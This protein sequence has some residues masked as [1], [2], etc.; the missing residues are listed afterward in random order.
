MR[1]AQVGRVDLSLQG[2]GESEGGEASEGKGERKGW[3]VGGEEEESH[4]C[5][6]PRRSSGGSRVAGPRSWQRPAPS[7]AQGYLGFPAGASHASSSR[8]RPCSLL[9][10]DGVQRSRRRFSSF[11]SG[12]VTVGGLVGPGSRM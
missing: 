10:T 1:D 7:S 9:E 12:T 8:C 2:G 11:I 5:A 4:G 3:G 6:A